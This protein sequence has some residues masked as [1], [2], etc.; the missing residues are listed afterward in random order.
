MIAQA[1]VGEAKKGPVGII[2]GGLIAAGFAAL[3]DSVVPKFAKGG[4][5]PGSGNQ[6]TVPALL[7]PGELILNQAQQ[8][9]LAGNM[10]NITINISA[11]LVDDTV[12]DS[13]IPAIERAKQLNIA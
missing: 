6:D 7:T 4:I 1:L 9:N 5:V 2:T 3:F 8:D 11:P 13:I 10:N 12:V